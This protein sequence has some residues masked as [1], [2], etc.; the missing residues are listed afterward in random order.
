M[1]SARNSGSGCPETRA[2][3]TPWMSEQ[4]LYSHASPGWRSIGTRASVASH[5]LGRVSGQPLPEFLAERIFEPARADRHRAFT[6]RREKL[7]RLPPI[8]CGPD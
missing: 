5:S 3:K 6:F 8:P 2:I 7:D 4:V 1:R